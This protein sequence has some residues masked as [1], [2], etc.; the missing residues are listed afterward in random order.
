MNTI[1]KKARQMA[2]SMTAAEIR[3][4]ADLPP[5]KEKD[6]GLW[7]KIA[8]EALTMTKRWEEIGLVHTPDSFEEV[9]KWAEGA[10]PPEYNHIAQVAILKTWNL[11][12]RMHNAEMEEANSDGH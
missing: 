9:Q 10:L 12:C 6:G 4:I 2:D 3:A 8:K 1:T 11:C 7:R 5:T